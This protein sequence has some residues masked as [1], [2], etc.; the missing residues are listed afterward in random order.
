[1]KIGFS[2]LIWGT[3]LLLAAVFV[4]F[5][6]FNGFT[7]LGIGSIIAAVL[8]VIFL[9]QC[10]ADRNFAL[11]PIPVAVLYIVFR[12]P[13]D[14]PAIR[15][16]TVILSS[17]LACIGL[18]ILLPRK[19][20]RICH[21]FKSGD[22]SGDTQHIHTEKSRLENSGNDNNPKVSVNF[23]AVSRHL[24]A[25]SLE[26]VQ[27]NCNFGA[28]EIFFDQTELSPNGAEV[29]LNCSIGA[30]K[31]YLPRHWRIVDRVSC[32]LGGVD[33]DKRFTTPDENA[34]QLIINGSVSLGGIE[35][36]YI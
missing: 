4:L 18:G 24:Y 36:R 35:V 27:L 31:I 3:F 15:T 34:P 10:I 26:T 12:A 14:L 23:G 1:M 5:N 19:Y 28:M 16:K 25:D 17:V 8:S 11:L 13:L 33:I 7:R 29:T 22:N 6:Q 21:E 9:V 32:S 30:I 2:K 20:G